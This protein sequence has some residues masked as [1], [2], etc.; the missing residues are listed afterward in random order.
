MKEP[1]PD[2]LRHIARDFD[3][4][5]RFRF[6]EASADQTLLLTTPKTFVL[7]TTSGGNVQ[8]DLPDPKGVPGH[9][10][11]VKKLTAANTLTIDGDGPELPVTLTTQYAALNFTSVNGSWYVW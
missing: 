4:V 11:A 1:T 2:R 6:I 10:C 7:A 8:L 3:K 9:L 5:T